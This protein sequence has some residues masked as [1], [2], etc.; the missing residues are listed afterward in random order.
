MFV[1]IDAN[2]LYAC[3]QDSQHLQEFV[4]YLIDQ[5]NIDQLLMHLI[6]LNK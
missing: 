6:K 4:F 1:H 2:E 5:R 3:L